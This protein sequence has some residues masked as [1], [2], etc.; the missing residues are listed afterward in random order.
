M[1]VLRILAAI[2][3]GWMFAGHWHVQAA[4]F[5]CMFA[6]VLDW[7]DGWFARRFGQVT[8]L[9]AHL[10]PVADK[11]LVAVVFVTLAFHFRWPWFTF[12]VSAMLA[13]EI[14]VTAYRATRR[15]R[16]GRLMPASRLG[17]AK[18]LVQCLVGNYL[19]FMVFVFPGAKPQATWIVLVMMLVTAFLTVDSGLRYL[20]P[21]CADGKKRSV[22]ERI[23][24][25]LFGVRARGS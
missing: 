4:A 17:K 6:S 25:A 19:L 16:T 9:G 2:A 15:R 23:A 8:S 12:L 7:L 11:I 5:L 18:T 21:S 20:L 22:T 14:A 1:T 10:D 24:Q 13:R 3:A